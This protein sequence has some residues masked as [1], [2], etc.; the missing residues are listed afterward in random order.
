MAW[1]GNVMDRRFPLPS[2]ASL[3]QLNQESAVAAPRCFDD[4]KRVLVRGAV[5]WAVLGALLA[6][7]CAVSQD[8]ADGGFVSG[9]AGLAGGGYDR[10]IAEREAA[11]QGE[12]EAGERLRAEAQALEKE[13]AA[14]KG[15]L[16]RVQVRLAEQNR[17]IAAERARLAARAA[18][19]ASAAAAPKARL[20]RLDQAQ[21]RVERARTN[22]R[23][24]SGGDLPVSEVKRLSQN[25]RAELDAIDNLVGSIGDGAL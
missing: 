17:R 23:K 3:S 21:V 1:M 13:R 20:R 4:L 22:L 19:S 18:A 25:L 7:G 5:A 14:L 24:A 8:P 6:G 9:V 12:V 15:E 2:A 10:R 16:T 11:H